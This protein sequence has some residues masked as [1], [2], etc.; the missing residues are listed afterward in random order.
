MIEE[1]A[2]INSQTD[3][4]ERF[5]VQCL[6]ETFRRRLFG[7]IV[8]ERISHTNSSAGFQEV[9]DHGVMDPYCLRYILT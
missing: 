2:N 4:S 1:D 7:V 5:N 9:D 8:K 3:L 6:V